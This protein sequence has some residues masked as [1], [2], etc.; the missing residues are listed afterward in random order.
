MFNA[1]LYAC[2]AC[3]CVLNSFHAILS[4]NFSLLILVAQHKTEVAA[5]SDNGHVAVEAKTIPTENGTLSET[6][7]KDVVSE[8]H[9]VVNVYDQ[10]VSPPVSGTRPKARY[11][12]LEF[13]LSPLFACI[14]CAVHFFLHAFV[15][16]ICYTHTCSLVVNII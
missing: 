8:G 11:E 16:Y 9:G 13:L 3:T 15:L 4:L 12:V 10:W 1:I 14:L 6:Q 2:E 5:A 7:D